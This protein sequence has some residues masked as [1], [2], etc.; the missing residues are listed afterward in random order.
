MT[1]DAH[2]RICHSTFLALLIPSLALCLGGALRA[3]F[4]EPPEPPIPLA[5]LKTEP[6]PE[7]ANLGEF[8]NCVS[9]TTDP[10][11]QARES[12][13]RLGKA[14]FWDMQVGSDGLT[15]CASCH[16]H[17]GA[18]NRRKNQLSPGL[19]R[20]PTP[21]T[22]FQIGGPNYTLEPKD[23]P[24]TK[25]AD[26]NA[27]RGSP[28]VS[29]ANDVT[30]S[31]GVFNT[32]FVDVSPANRDAVDACNG[33]PDPVFQ[34]HAINVRR[35]EPRNTPSMV[36]AVFNFDNF[37]D[38]RADHTFNGVSPFGDLDPNARVFKMN[39]NGQV[40]AVQVEIEPASLASQA[41]GPPLSAFEMSCAG[42]FW[43]KVG[44]KLLAVGL[45]PL[46]KQFVDSTDSVLGP[47]ARGSGTPGSGGLT[48]SYP[49]MVRQAFRFEWWGGGPII[50]G[51]ETFTQMEANFSLF[52]G[53]AVQL[54]EATLVADDTRLD[55]FL[56]VNGNTA[57]LTNLEKQGMDI[58]TGTGRCSQ[59]HG[60]A[61]LTNASVSNVA[62]QRLERM[63][64]GDNGCAIYDNGFYNIG[65]RPTAEDISRGG[66]DPFGNPLS[67]T[68][69]AMMNP[70][71][72]VD[73]NLSPPL[74]AVSECD[75]RANVDGT[76]KTPALRNVELSGPFF[77]NGGKATLMQVVQFYNR[78][79]DFAQQNIRNLDPDIQPLDL[80][81][82]QMGALVAFLQALTDERVRQE[83][84]PFDHPQLFRPNGCIGDHKL[85][86]EER[87]GTGGTGRCV[88][89]MEQV[90][91][92]GA[93]GRPAA[94]IVPLQPFMTVSQMTGSGQLATGTPGTA[95]F[96]M[97][98]KLKD[99]S[100]PQGKLRYQDQAQRTSIHAD[101]ITRHES[102]ETCV[103]VW[104]P[105]E[106]NDT[107]GFSFTAK[108]CDNRQPGVNRDFFELTVWDGAGTQVYFNAGFLT[109]GN[110]QAHIE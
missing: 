89:D 22:T 44:R 51:G 97:Q 19:L 99:G 43:P 107:T 27:A 38:G 49:D 52:W 63:I 3:Q 90:P 81:P 50:I 30:S 35:V 110:L 83:T 14:L 84:A 82:A 25:H 59:C 85:V 88:D 5:S 15:A 8:L 78:G 18:D 1:P 64:M 34:V 71:R 72:F 48:L 67:D 45:I 103:R 47:F 74:G 106:V 95:N 104:G 9:A 62:N 93:G 32:S 53:L 40:E 16:F 2:R 92:V 57:A 17:A 55:Q 36:N 20:S 80:T 61:E 98:F 65:V 108:G 46:G 54:F 33:K 29:D 39:A 4:V 101:T 109:G 24:F 68:R 26:E 6:V 75:N 91:A 79:G 7:P 94:G 87:A 12:A 96:G 102:T 69:R 100:P 60:G 37:W 86:A 76:F 42:R 66:T 31:M 77:H 21:D 41:V 73:Q 11:S 56:D 13:I 105:A 70:P 58:F 10:C 23:F 28:I